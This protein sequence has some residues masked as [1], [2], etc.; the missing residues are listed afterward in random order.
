MWP[1]TRIP[2]PRSAPWPVLAR[3][4]PD[5]GT[6]PAPLPR[7][8]N[9]AKRL[10]GYTGLP[11]PVRHGIAAIARKEGWSRSRVIAW[12][13][14]DWFKVNPETGYVLGADRWVPNLLR[15]RS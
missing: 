15:H 3:T 6:R 11:E 13:V 2:A 7:L 5:A 8:P 12:L 4:A 14:C 10:P 9:K 1:D